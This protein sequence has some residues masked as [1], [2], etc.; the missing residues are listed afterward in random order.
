MSECVC[1]SSSHRAFQIGRVFYRNTKSFSGEEIVV[2]MKVLT[3]EVNI[4]CV[5]R[6][7]PLCVCV[8]LCSLCSVCAYVSFVC[9]CVCVP[10][11]G[12]IGMC[13]CLCVLTSVRFDRLELPK[14]VVS[15][16]GTK[17]KNLAHLMELMEGCKVCAVFRV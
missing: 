3:D 6:L 7:Y 8:C 1:V 2:I 11:S 4:G 15:L 14:Q 5:R 17:I 12:C 9:V 10:V 13:V 16:N